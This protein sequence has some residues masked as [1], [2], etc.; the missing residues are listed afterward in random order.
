M[1]YK[2]L[3]FLFLLAV[4][5]VSCNTKKLEIENPD[6]SDKVKACGGG[7]GLSESLN[8]HITNLH[9]DLPT[10]AKL[11]V[12]FQEQIKLLLFA[13]LSELPAKDRL[14]A[15]EDYQQCIQKL[16]VDLKK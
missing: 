6:L 16:H 14:K 9:R 12:G 4:I 7:I 10:D 8:A 3:V 1:M 11:G 5:L 2:R 13:E 15:I